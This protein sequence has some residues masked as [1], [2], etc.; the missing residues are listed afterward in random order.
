M[1]IWKYFM[2]VLLFFLML[3]A[4]A[5]MDASAA[6]YENAIYIYMCGSTLETGRGCA[7]T[8][9]SEMLSADIP[10]DTCI[11]I[12]TG[13]ARRWRDYDISPEHLTRLLITADGMQ[14]IEKIDAASM[15][16]KDTLADFLEF[17]N[18]NYPA[19]N[20]GLVF[21]DHGGGSI[22]GV[23][24]DEN[25]N[26]DALTI[27]E[28]SQVLGIVTQ[29]GQRKYDFIGFDACLM[30]N[31]E[32]AGAIYG[33]ADYMI[34]SEELEALGGWN[35]VA[36]A[37]KFGEDTFYE[38]L[39]K[40]YSE[41]CEANAVG[42]YTLSCIDLTEFELVKTA[43]DDF[44][45]HL[46]QLA[47]VGLQQIVEAA[48]NSVIFGYNSEAEGYSNMIDLAVFADNL[49]Y[50]SLVD[51]IEKVTVRVSSPTKETAEG[52]S[53]FYPLDD[54]KQVER[55]V[56]NGTSESYTRFLAENYSEIPTDGVIE[57]E[58]RGS[59]RGEELYVS[60][61]EDSMKYIKDV[62][63]KLF[64]IIDLNDEEQMALCMGTDMDIL[65]DDSAYTTS[66]DSKWV[67][68]NE[69]YVYLSAIEYIG[70]VITVATPILLNGQVGTVRFAYDF[71]EG[72]FTLYGFLP[73]ANEGAI[74]RLQEIE[75]GDEVTLIYQEI[76]SEYEEVWCYGS[77]FIYHEGS[78]FRIKTIPEGRYLISLRIRD[79]FGNIYRS[80]TELLEYKNGRTKCLEI[81][82]D[83]QKLKFRT[84]EERY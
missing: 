10:E 14:E 84:A 11:V 5:P 3:S 81:L 6:K 12:E 38:E 45:L 34:A 68:W 79:V 66:F 61:T 20:T 59:A 78:N 22:K 27:P 36:L 49:Q 29:N 65:V 33:Y 48:E 1:K 9:I 4:C 64:Q 55:Y 51:A 82:D 40:G 60:V 57:F 56:I 18:E 75:D 21:W 52:I 32:T 62:E 44:S 7:T 24:F 67:T 54:V 8:N 39:L 28:F 23:C 16:D 73:E 19:E 13:G 83:I 80:N 17:C 43:F 30:A 63:Y 53:I 74:S 69:E 71:S 72:S 50:P 47:D 15:G 70:D 2:V 41:K 46:E 35:Y 42:V 31:Y 77:S 26:M 76:S 25:Y 37:E 58:D